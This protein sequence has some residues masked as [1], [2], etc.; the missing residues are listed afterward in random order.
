MEMNNKTKAQEEMNAIAEGYRETICLA[1]KALAQNKELLLH[2]N[3][4]DKARLETKIA[5]WNT[6]IKE[7]TEIYNMLVNYYYPTTNIINH[8]VRKPRFSY[9][10]SQ[11]L[12][13]FE[14][15]NFNV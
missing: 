7:N 13:E 8:N 10:I 2:S 12:N 11:V 1:K 15:G 6:V 5:L 9:A 3:A 14:Q 4:A